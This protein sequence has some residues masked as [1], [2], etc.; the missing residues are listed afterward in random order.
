MTQR[1]WA[2]LLAVPL[3][4]A[5]GLYAAVTPLPFVTYAP[6]L[7][8]D[9]LGHNGDKPIISVQGHRTYRDS[10]Q[11]RMTTVSVTE[12]NARLDLFTLMRTWLSRD[13]AVYPFSAVYGSSGSQQQDAQE[14]QVE[15]VTSQD[16]AVA[17]A[18]QQLGYDLNPAVE[19]VGV[20]PHMP[21]DGKLQV[22]DLLVRIGGT[23]VTPKTDVASLIAE[24]PPGRSVPIVVD[25]GGKKVRVRV[26]PTTSHGH[27]VVGVT[28]QVLYRFPFKVSVNISDAI[29]G[30]SAG[31]MFALSVYDTLTPGSLTDGG[32]VA[33]TGTITADGTVGEIG[34]IQQK[35][36]GARQDGA[37]LFLV[38][39]ANCADAVSSNHG[40]MRLAEAA[41]LKDAIS[42]V[43][44]WASDHQAPLPQCKSGNGSGGGS[45]S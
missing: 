33:G 6:G 25:R 36:A 2:A 37:Q 28:L 30:P 14:G 44:T 5:F 18:L 15:M 31:L 10:G 4:V 23:K 27:R 1:T 16:S 11:L 35:I 32:S 22:R 21:A 17:A 7:T 26:T 40:S 12:R 38:P 24:V 45:S 29:G 13:D 41:T 43:Q 34:G 20:T 39:P 19:I 8:V 9:V 3:F 42:E